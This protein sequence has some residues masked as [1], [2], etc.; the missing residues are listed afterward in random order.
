MT[1]DS[2]SYI[3]THNEVR[4]HQDARENIDYL[5]HVP[6]LNT[7]LGPTFITKKE[8]IK[9]AISSSFGKVKVYLSFM[10]FKIK[11]LRPCEISK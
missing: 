3:L 1:L 5:H 4:K 9:Q 2:A 6:L 8:N 11:R 10:C 7:S